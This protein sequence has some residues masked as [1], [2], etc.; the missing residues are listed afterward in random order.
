MKIAIAGATG[1]VGK[2]VIKELAKTDHELVLLVKDINAAAKVL[3]TL[4]TDKTIIQQ[5]NILNTDEVVSAT[6]D[7]D[8]L[9]WMVP[10]I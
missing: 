7:C 6:K 4:N 5:T 2:I 8:V 9:F 1:N 10:P 3:E